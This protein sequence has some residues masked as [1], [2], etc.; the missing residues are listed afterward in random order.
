MTLSDPLGTWRV[1]Y[2]AGPRRVPS[3]SRSSP[4]QVL[5]GSQTGLPGWSWLSPGQVPV[6]FQAGLE[7]LSSKSRAG[8]RRVSGKSRAGPD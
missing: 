1:K 2:W 8:P 7:Q 4:S 6:G 3:G 5:G